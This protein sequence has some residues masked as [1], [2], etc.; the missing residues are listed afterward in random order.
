M[1]L[2]AEV[3]TGREGPKIMGF[4]GSIQGVELFILVDSG[5][6]HTF[7]STII[8]TQL[9][10]VSSLHSAVKVKVVNGQTVVCQQQFVQASW[11]IDGVQF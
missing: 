4:V 7:I 2:S 1:L 6:S 9:V 5:S 3:A 10:G 8:A 11:N